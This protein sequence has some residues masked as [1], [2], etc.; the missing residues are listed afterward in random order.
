M[1]LLSR[2][3]E[4]EFE[5]TT[6]IDE[7]DLPP[8]AMLSH[9]WN[10]GQ[11]VIFDELVA[12]V[13]KKKIGN[14]KIRFCAERA[15]QDG[16]QYFWVDTCCINKRDPTELTAAINSMFRWYQRADKC[17]V[18]LSDVQV[19][20]EV[21]NIQT[22]R[23]TWEAAFRR[24]RWFTRG[25]TLQELLAP[26]TV[27]FFSR[28]G[29]ILGSKLSLEQEIHDITQI[30]IGA[31]RNHDV[32]NFSIDERM[33]WVEKRKTT[34]KE[35]R[36]YCL[37]G[38]FGVFLPL[39]YGEGEDHAFRRLRKEIAGEVGSLGDPKVAK[40]PIMPGTLHMLIMMA[41][42]WLTKCSLI[43]ITIFT[44]RILRRTQ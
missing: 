11:E 6:F 3:T 13:G 33:R 17:Y 10:D 43:I 18:Y 41:A 24:S 15:V 8:Y 44:Q 14:T 4:E 39:I 16:L 21:T 30:P 34:I 32:R 5:L 20:A 19:P 36:V 23:S 35:D 7:D 37:L 2:K 28:D 42:I 1:R 22:F 27:E 40:I 38:I 29:R 9:T 26:G 25:W 31:L 12:G